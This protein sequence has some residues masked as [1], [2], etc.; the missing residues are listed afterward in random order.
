MAAV[1]DVRLTE[2]HREVVECN[3]PAAA[4]RGHPVDLV[5]GQRRLV[6]LAE[7]ALDLPEAKPEVMAADAGQA[8]CDS[9][10][11]EIRN[12]VEPPCAERDRT[13]LGQASDQSVEHRWSVGLGEPIDLI[14][15]DQRPAEPFG[16][17]IELS[18]VGTIDGAGDP[19]CERIS[20][21]IEA[22]A[23][24]P[25]D[26]TAPTIGVLPQ[27]RRLAATSRAVGND[28][29]SLGGQSMEARAIESGQARRAGGRNARQ[30]DFGVPRGVQ[31]GHRAVSL[32]KTSILT[33]T[34]CR[35]QW[36]IPR[37]ARQRARVASYTATSSDLTATLMWPCHSRGMAGAC[38][39][40]RI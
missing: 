37:P 32:R 31:F 20:R 23:F 14:D 27:E 36:R 25:N 15:D 35:R 12:D 6:D 30:R 13:T 26:R 34:G 7:Q 40:D 19:A 5:D 38:N 22:V 24:E 3:W 4:R 28:D 18:V 11:L 39:N 10:T 1:D 8:S 21:S 17:A 2:G 29:T 16:H 9:P 33:R